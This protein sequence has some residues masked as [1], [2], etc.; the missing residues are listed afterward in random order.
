[1]YRR[2][3]TLKLTEVLEVRTASIV[4]AMNDRAVDGCS[5]HL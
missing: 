4:R 1:M 5:T 2:V 3:D